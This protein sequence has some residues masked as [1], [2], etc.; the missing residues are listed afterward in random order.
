METVSK[1]AEMERVL[2]FDAGS[3]E[4]ILVHEFECVYERV[5]C[6]TG[7]RASVLIVEENQSFKNGPPGS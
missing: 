4:L 2:C 6:P 3:G 7:P 1:A 5:G